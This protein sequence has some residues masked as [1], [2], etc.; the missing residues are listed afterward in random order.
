M[1]ETTAPCSAVFSE[2]V[3]A[4]RASEELGRRFVASS[5][6]NLPNVGHV[7]STFWAFNA[8]RRQNSK[9]LLFLSNNS[10]GLLWAVL[11]HFRYGLQLLRELLAFVCTLGTSQHKASFSLA[12]LLWYKPCSAFGTKLHCSRPQAFLFPLPYR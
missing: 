9:F 4:L 8:H 6:L 12:L 5:C 11:N 7:V 1:L 3:V 2:G 10:N